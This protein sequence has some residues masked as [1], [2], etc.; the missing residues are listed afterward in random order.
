MTYSTNLGPP[1]L[2]PANTSSIFTCRPIH[3]NTFL[4]PYGFNEFP[5][6][7]QQQGFQS[8]MINVTPASAS[9]QLYES[10]PSMPQQNFVS[11]E[12]PTHPA[13]LSSQPQMSAISCLPKL[14]L[15]TFSGDSLNWRTFWDSFYAAIHANPSLSG[16]Q[17]FN[18]LKA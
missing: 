8:S 5:I 4:A 18:Y 1:P 17:K 7:T 11:P 10:P 12:I 13:I 9:R 15:P 3:F 2:I 14:T 6:N 16:I